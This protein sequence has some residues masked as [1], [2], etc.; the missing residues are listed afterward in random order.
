MKEVIEGVVV[1]EGMKV[2]MEV[3]M[4]VD[5]EV[6]IEVDIEVGMEVD[7]EVDMEVGIEVGMEVDLEEMDLVHLVDLEVVEEEEIMTA[8]KGTGTDLRKATI[9]VHL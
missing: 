8:T 6:G 5:M 3:G 4:E 1:Q 2:G 7:M 9:Q